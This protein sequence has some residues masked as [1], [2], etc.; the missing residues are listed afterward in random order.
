M[1]CLHLYLTLDCSLMLTTHGRHE[2]LRT[3]LG[4]AVSHQEFRLTN[5]TSEQCGFHSDN[6]MIEQGRGDTMQDTVDAIAEQYQC[7]PRPMI[8]LHL[9]W[10]LHKST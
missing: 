10:K 2:K 8:N 9:S 1:L 3:G 5:Q 7:S 4:I 6:M